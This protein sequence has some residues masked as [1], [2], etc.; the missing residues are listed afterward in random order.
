MVPFFC[1]H[2]F[3]VT[4]EVRCPR[5]QG[6]PWSEFR[7]HI[8]DF[9]Q[10]DQCCQHINSDFH[11]CLQQT[12]SDQ[13]IYISTGSF[14]RTY[15]I[16][17]N[18]TSAVNRSTSIYTGALR[19]LGRDGLSTNQRT[20]LNTYIRFWATGS[21]QSIY[22]STV[23]EGLSTYLQVVLIGY[24]NFFLGKD[25]H[26]MSSTGKGLSVFISCIG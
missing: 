1:Y 7:T 8:S 12:K 9:D 5:K 14:E 2:Q 22:I 13:S 4:K 6:F 26:N 17:T 3:K 25:I 11:K 18:L 16:L 15:P 24:I 10:P 20:V 23:P 21:V 19:R